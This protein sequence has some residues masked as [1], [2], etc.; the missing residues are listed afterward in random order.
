MENYGLFLKLS[1]RIHVIKKEYKY[2]DFKH[3]KILHRL[4]ILN[5]LPILYQKLYM[6]TFILPFEI[7]IYLFSN[8]PYHHGYD[9]IG[10]KLNRI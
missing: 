8:E 3:E 1:V 9:D 4:L 10:K 5:N 7:Q 2:F 6:F